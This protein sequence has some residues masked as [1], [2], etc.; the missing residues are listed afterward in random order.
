MAALDTG[1]KIALLAESV[2]SKFTKGVKSTE[3][4]VYNKLLAIV[5]GLEL[6]QDGT[7]K[8]NQA[9]IKIL[10]EVRSSIESIILT[11]AYRKRVNEYLG[12][13][14]DL[15]GVNDTYFAVVS[16]A[17]KP[18]KLLYEEVK[19]LSIAAT[20]KSLMESGINQFVIDPINELLN[21]NVTSG[22]FFSDLV[23]QMRIA[24]LGD[25]ERLGKLERYA[26]QITRDSLNQ[27]SANYQQAISSDLG[28]EW[29]YYSGQL[30]SDSRSYCIARND[31]FFHEKEVERSATLEWSGKIPGTNS[32]SIFIYRGGFSCQHSYLPVDIS[33]VPKDVIDRN[34]ANGNF[35]PNQ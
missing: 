22:G 2:A 11:D 15:K 20:K 30:V 23:E 35:T 31:K 33:Q 28:F 24:I 3:R 21:Q 34:I 14:D 27:Y 25:K 10:R 13:F 29:Y 12:G 5:K 1:D 16:T 8:T 6:N 4:D 18:N 19:K 32:S 17:F 26:S 9:N 7:I